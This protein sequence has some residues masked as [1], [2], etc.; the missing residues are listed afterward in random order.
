MGDTV[1]RSHLCFIKCLC[2][3]AW[4]LTEGPDV[5][6]RAPWLGSQLP[7]SYLPELGEG[8][9]VSKAPGTPCFLAGIRPTDP[10][11]TCYRLA[12]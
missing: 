3:G 9:K 8:E 11:L 12:V 1:I 4:W 5:G 6:G 2:P 7:D 10:T